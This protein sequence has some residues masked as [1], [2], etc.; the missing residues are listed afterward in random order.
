AAKQLIKTLKTAGDWG[1]NPRDF[2]IEAIDQ[3]N[4]SN[5]DEIRLALLA[6]KYARHARGGRIANPTK[7]LSSYLDKKPLLIEPQTVVSELATASDVQVYLT[8]LH[9]KSEAFTNLRTALLKLREGREE[10]EEQVQIPL[11][12]P[13]LK[14]GRTHPHVALLRER[15]GLITPE[16]DTGEPGDPEYFDPGLA[17]AV[18]EWQDQNGLSA[19]GVVGR[20]T[21]RA[22]AGG[23]RTVTEDM[24]IANM[25]MWR[26][27]PDDLG[28]LHVVANIPEYKVRVIDDGQVTFEERVIVGKTNKQTPVFSDVMEKI[29]FNPMWGVPNSIKVK[30]L[31]PSLARGGTYFQRQNL[32]I[33]YKGRSVD[34][35]SVN[36]AQAD[37]RNYHV[38]QPPGRGNVLGV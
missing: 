15:L 3:N 18:K 33:S 23:P 35:R 32:R 8:S 12:G 30:E 1:L 10:V 6:T 13:L 2:A 26:W 28:K 25:E 16:S 21:R 37:I 7:D 31:L 4:P 14:Q 5:D 22:F 20:Q 27:K 9:P 36:W 34:P 11:S 17:A 24:I 29:V 38:Y 19:D